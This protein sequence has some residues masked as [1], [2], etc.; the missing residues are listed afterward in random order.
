MRSLGIRQG[1]E[2]NSLLRDIFMEFDIRGTFLHGTPFGNGHIHDTY[3]IAT[4]GTDGRKYIFQRFNSNV[5]KDIQKVQENISRVT[6]HLRNKLA[7]I[8]GSDPDRETL[9]IIPARDGRL[10]ITGPDGNQWRVFPFIPR[11]KSYDVVG[12]PERAFEGGRMVG[13][14]QAL[15]SDLGD[16]PLHETI[17]FF[18]NSVKRLETLFEKV[19][20]DSAGR[21]KMVLNELAFVEERADN[22]TKIHNL[23]R[24]GKIPVRITHNDT[25]FNNILFDEETGKAL[26]IIDLDTVMPGH[27]HYDFGDAIR[28]AANTGSEDDTDLSKVEIDLSI[29]RAYTTGYLSE[30]KRYLNETEIEYLPF[31]P[32]VVTFIQ[33]VRFLTDFIDGDKYYK[34]HHDMHNLQRARA[35]FKL[36]Q[37]MEKHYEEMAGIVG[38]IIRH[39]KGKSE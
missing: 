15:L 36:V 23:G 35:Q 3:L 33:G 8:P 20:E 34:I 14:F 21:V 10:W 16:P 19:R 38:E 28:T 37:S 12:S 1:S 31:A 5:F 25:K 2:N 26:C 7:A 27:V 22:M 11:H 30:I 4:T 13:R 6:I 39:T 9:T 18:H 17:P 24:E 32:L 29:F